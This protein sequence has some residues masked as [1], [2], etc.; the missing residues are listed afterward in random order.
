MY[1]GH[2]RDINIASKKISDVIS[3]EYATDMLHY[4]G[5]YVVLI[6]GSFN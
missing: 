6:G 2:V 4:A 3:F 1:I 5:S